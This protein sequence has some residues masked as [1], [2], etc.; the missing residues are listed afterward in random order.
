MFNFYTKILQGLYLL[1]K[2]Q[3]KKDEKGV[4]QFVGKE[5]EKMNSFYKSYSFCKKRIDKRWRMVYP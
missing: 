2:K 4:R 5:N 1:L 3:G